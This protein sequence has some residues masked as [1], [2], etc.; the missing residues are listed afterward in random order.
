MV[1]LVT[2]VSSAAHPLCDEPDLLF[3]AMGGILPCRGKPLHPILESVTMQMLGA[4]LVA[5]IG[6]RHD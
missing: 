6:P 1:C 4:A 2:K 5:R 3:S